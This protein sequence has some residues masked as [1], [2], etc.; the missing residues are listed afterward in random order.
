MIQPPYQV[1]TYSLEVFSDIET[2]VSAYMKLANGGLSI[3]LESIKDSQRKSRYSVF[4]MKPMLIF[5]RRPDG[6][7]IEDTV[8]NVTLRPE[9]NP[10][11]H[12]K[13]VLAGYTFD[14][15]EPFECG[16][17]AGY[18][19]Y[20]AIRYIERIPDQ[21]A[22]DL[23]IP[24][25]LMFIPSEVILFDHETHRMKLLIHSVQDSSGRLTQEEAEHRLY[26]MM[27]QLSYSTPN[28]R[29]IP[30]EAELP[31]AP[32]V[33]LNMTRQDYIKSIEKAKSY[34]QQ[35]DIFQVVFSRRFQALIRCRAFDIYQMLRLINPSP[36]M[37]YLNTP[38]GFK[39]VGS[40]P[41]TMVKVSDGR[42][43]L[44]PIAGTR[45]RGAST[46][47]DQ[48]IAGELLQDEKELAEHHMLVDLGRN[49]LGRMAEYG[50]VRVDSFRQIENYSHVMHIVSTASGQLKPDHDA[51]DVFTSCFPAGTVSGAPKIRAMEIIDELEPTRRN[52][53]AG[54]V[55]YFD[56]QNRLDSCIAI[57]TLLVKDQ[58]AYWQ[59][60]G[61]IVADSDPEME[62][63]ESENKA[64]AILK[65]LQ[66]AE[67]MSNGHHDR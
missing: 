32:E 37:F 57:R 44:R 55:G 4:G 38:E 60:G 62:L 43:T 39:I 36:Y 2:P 17:I 63:A 16:F 3:L 64:Q 29:E 23:N 30:P 31:P 12:L 9:G 33:T 8:K 48:R 15:K 67:E 66:M 7:E 46:E 22:D 45:K 34:I 6:T 13:I 10:F 14:R 54:A 26:A 58:I 25:M 56:F 50:S 47:E 53:Y 28:F 41:E 42:M 40:S 35:G 24:E 65:A 19:S 27:H 11:D 59:A 21:T 51:V 20:D 1:K 5:R 18:I 52:I 61:G 49:D